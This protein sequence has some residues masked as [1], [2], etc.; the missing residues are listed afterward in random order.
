MGTKGIGLSEV[1]CATTGF[2]HVTMFAV[3]VIPSFIMNQLSHY[4]APSASEI[5]RIL[6]L[7]KDS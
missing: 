2:R 1:L 4:S 6:G 7:A 3:S 5:G